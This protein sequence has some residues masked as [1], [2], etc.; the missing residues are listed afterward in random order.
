M[1]PL[2]IVTQPP[3]ASVTVDG[4]PRGETP[5]VVRVPRGPHEVTLAKSRYTTFVET[6]R[7]PGKIDRNLRRPMATL[8][9][10]ASAANASVVVQGTARGTAPIKV[11]L[12]GFETYQIEVSSGGAS[13]WRKKVY[14]KA[15]STTVQASLAPP[16]RA[17]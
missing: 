5:L 1:V 17:R 14:V 16:H 15:P 9:V 4:K 7:A 11:Q 6:V 13:P 3:G 12:P 2:S 10:N 8:Y